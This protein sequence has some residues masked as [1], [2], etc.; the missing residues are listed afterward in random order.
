M[1][2]QRRWCP[3]PDRNRSQ[4]LR[5]FATCNWHNPGRLSILEAPIDKEL[6][7]GPPRE[8]NE[9]NV[10]IDQDLCT[11]DGLCEEIASDAFLAMDEGH[12]YALATNKVE[13]YRNQR[14]TQER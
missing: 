12:F 3:S 14:R 6:T 13:P 10:W 7:L 11:G 4:S 9:V 8:T 5:S 1:K 2:A